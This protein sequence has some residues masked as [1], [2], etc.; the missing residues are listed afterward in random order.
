MLALTFGG[1][2]FAVVFGIVVSMVW[3]AHYVC[4]GVYIAI[5]H[6]L[7]SLV[8]WERTTLNVIGGSNK[9]HAYIRSKFPW[10]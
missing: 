10:L 2:L 4:V 7:F 1:L 8:L 3:C 5:F 6:F 9:N